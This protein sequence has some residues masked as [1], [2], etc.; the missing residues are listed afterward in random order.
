MQ[1]VRCL[2]RLPASTSNST[3]S[4]RDAP[5]EHAEDFTVERVTQR[6]VLDPR[7]DVRVAVD[8]DEVH[9]I[10]DL[11][12]VHAVEAAADE[13]GG[14][15]G[16]VDHPA[17]RLADGERGRIALDELLAFADLV[18]LPVARRHEVLADEKRPL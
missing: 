14:A 6:L 12:E 1:P 11:L 2:P 8:L 4:L 15:H 16:E 17:G 5:R 10:L 13:V 9:A 18:D 7:V 3:S